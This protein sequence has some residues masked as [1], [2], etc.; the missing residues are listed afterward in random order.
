MIK[1]SDKNKTGSSI[2]DALVLPG[3]KFEQKTN[4]VDVDILLVAM[5]VQS[6]VM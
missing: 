3:V 5:T 4:S 1:V 6:R 2:R